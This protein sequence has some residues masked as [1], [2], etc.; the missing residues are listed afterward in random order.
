MAPGA[1]PK[2]F[3]RY[4]SGNNVFSTSQNDHQPLSRFHDMLPE[5]LVQIQ[6]EP[7]LIITITRVL[8]PGCLLQ[9]EK[10]SV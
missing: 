4:G 9:L 2:G 3:R 10:N 7:L 6:V 8:G 1:A 5:R